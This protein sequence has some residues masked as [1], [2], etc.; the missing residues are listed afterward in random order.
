METATLFNPYDA[1]RVRKMAALYFASFW[2]ILFTGAVRKWIFPHVAILYLFQ[3]VPITAAYLYAL[4]SG[5]FTRGLILVGSLLLSVI[6][7]L[8]G[9]FQVINST[10]TVLVAIV[11]FH[12]YL[13]YLPML[14]VFPLCLTEKYR[15]DFIR[16]NMWLSLPMTLLVIA[17]ALSPKNAFV[18][19]TSEGDAFG[20]PGVEV[21]RVSGTFNFVAFFAIWISTAMALCLGEWLLPKSR[22]VIQS[23]WLL[24]ACTFGLVLSSLISGSRSIILLVVIALLGALLAAGM[25]GS[26]RSIAAILGFCLLLPVAGAA[27]YFISPVEFSTLRDRLTGESGAAE[28][29]S[30]VINIFYTWITEPKFSLIGAGIGMGVDASH[31]GNVNSYNFTYELSEQD[32]VRNVME[33]GT[34]VGLAYVFLRIGFLVGI[35]VL[36]IRIVRTGTSPHVLPLSFILFAQGMEDLT[37]AATMTSTQVMIGCVYILGAQIYPDQHSLQDQ[38]FEHPGQI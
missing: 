14:V 8:Q 29:K 36:A 6:L 35:I 16:W 21:A 7:V 15:R 23:T 13:Y 38:G 34:P 2:C 24:S 25:L 27:T 18:N 10:N 22:R 32:V 30:R 26:G 5:L 11:G 1:L 37:R 9:L 3:D 12:H 4:W 28:G 17:Q 33:L 31:F 20:L 19:R